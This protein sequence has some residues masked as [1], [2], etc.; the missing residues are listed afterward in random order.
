MDGGELKGEGED[1]RSGERRNGFEIL[2]I[3]S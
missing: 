3:S 2:T 1:G